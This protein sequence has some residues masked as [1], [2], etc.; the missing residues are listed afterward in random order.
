VPNG[1]GFVLLRDAELH[2]EAFAGS[3]AYLTPGAGENLHELGV[4]ASRSWRGACVWAVLKQL[5]RDGVA[6]LVSR[7]CELAQELAGIVE[8]T[9]SLELTAPAPTNVVCFRYRPRGSNE[10]AELDE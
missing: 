8:S 6:E 1:V 3:A 4:E 9:P 5:G 10:G 2:R 7:C